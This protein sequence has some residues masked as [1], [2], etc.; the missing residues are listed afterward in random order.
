MG[1]SWIQWGIS[2]HSI[3]FVLAS[4]EACMLNTDGRFNNS[5]KHVVIFPDIGN[6]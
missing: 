2:F 5:S 4:T 6:C 3:L 1:E